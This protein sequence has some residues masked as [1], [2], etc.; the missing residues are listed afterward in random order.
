MADPA[1]NLPRMSAKDYLD[2]E[3]MATSRH[4]FFDGIV[5]AMSDARRRHNDIALDLRGLL[6]VRLLPPRRP[7]AVDVK[8]QVSPQ[9]SSDYFYPDGMVTCSDLDSDAQIVKQPLLII[10]VLSEGTRDFGRHVKFEAYRRLPSLE[11]YMLVE[12]DVRCVDLFRKRTSWAPEVFQTGE[13]F[14]LECVN[15]MLSVDEIY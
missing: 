14:T 12:Q 1:L 2:L 6:K 13:T 5:Y 4:E 7:Y 11:E 10:E 3:R 15:V 9:N 8:V